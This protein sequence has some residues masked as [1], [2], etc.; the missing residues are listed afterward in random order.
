MATHARPTLTRRRGDRGDRLGGTQQLCF[1][2]GG[3]ASTGGSDWG[4]ERS[5]S[6]STAPAEIARCGWPTWRLSADSS[7][8]RRPSRRRPENATQAP[9][10]GMVLTRSQPGGNVAPVPHGLLPR[11]SATDPAARLQGPQPRVR[12]R[13][14]RR[15][16]P[17]RPAVR[18][19]QPDRISGC[20]RSGPAHRATTS[21]TAAEAGTGPGQQARARSL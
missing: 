4:A 11:A 21:A 15:P 13:H 20:R 19:C 5:A 2:E 1:Y 6:A 9:Q 10:D 7:F 3:L 14:R 8:K 17:S 16:A 12:R 18:R